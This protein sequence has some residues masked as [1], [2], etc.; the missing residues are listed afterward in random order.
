MCGSGS[1]MSS[2]AA[3]LQLSHFVWM[4]LCRL[5]A[6]I[7]VLQRTWKWSTPSSFLSP[8]TMKSCTFLMLLI[9]KAMGRG[10]S[11][12]STLPSPFPMTSTRPSHVCMLRLAVCVSISPLDMAQVLRTSVF[13]TQADPVQRYFRRPPRSGFPPTRPAPSISFSALPV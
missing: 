12:F 11:T 10:S 3:S 6:L 7:R 8:T 1:S 13:S 5:S 9:R 4:A 2:M